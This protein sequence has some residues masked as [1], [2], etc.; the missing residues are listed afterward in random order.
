MAI[1]RPKDLK[2]PLKETE[3]LIEMANFGPD[4]TGLSHG[5]IYVD[6]IKTKHG[7]RVKYYRG[8]PGNDKPSASITVNK[9]PQLVQD[10]INI[11]SKEL[12]EVTAFVILNYTHLMKVYLK[13]DTMDY[14][15][16]TEK[17]KPI[18]QEKEVK[19]DKTKD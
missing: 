12:K 2:K 8:R 13:G 17:I 4:K 10:S 6:N 5:T 1:L 9:E 7:A 15:Q 11:T 14:K 18:P 16:W 19:K 3:K